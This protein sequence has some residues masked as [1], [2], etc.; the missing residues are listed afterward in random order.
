MPTI[1]FQHVTV[2]FTD[3]KSKKVVMPL[4]DL[5]A[6]FLDGKSYAIL[7]KSGAGKTT[8]LRTVA[9]F[10]PYE[11]DLF[12]D[13]VNASEIRSKERNIAYV[14]QEY[15]LYPFLNV[16]ENLAFPLKAMG[17]SKAEIM[18]RVKAIAE[19]L[20]L[21]YLLTRKPRYLSGGQQQR[22]AI[23]RALIKNP[24]ICLFDEPF[25]NLEIPERRRES[26]WL[27]SWMHS[28]GSTTLYV[29]HSAQEA[30]AMAENIMILE[31]GKIALQMTR[32][33]FMV[34]SHPLAVAFKGEEYD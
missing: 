28:L 11:G 23:G 24:D 21:S 7:G 9:G 14:S 25:S 2:R 5:N 10:E 12:F 15:A 32:E 20:G 33:E 27:S 34:S 8:L 17:S 16:F 29:T 19:Q 4:R 3:N 26:A 22:V 13:G 18:H 6:V 30:Y 1:A 31:N